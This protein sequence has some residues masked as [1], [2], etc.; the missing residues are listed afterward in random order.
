M[1]HI[2]PD[3][4]TRGGSVPNPGSKWAFFPSS[5]AAGLQVEWDPGWS[6]GSGGQVRGQARGPAHGG[7]TE[8]STHGLQGPE[9][10]P[11]LR[12]HMA[13]AELKEKGDTGP[14]I[15]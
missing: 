13:E 11:Q 12:G 1:T 7:R 9:H 10:P 15:A 4:G 14:P 3:R 2:H 6:W 5:S 8:G